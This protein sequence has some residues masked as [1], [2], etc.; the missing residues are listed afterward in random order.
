[1]SSV[2]ETDSTWWSTFGVP[3]FAAGVAIVPTCY[4]FARKTAEQLERPVPRWTVGEALKAGFKAIPETALLVGSQMV[5][6]PLVKSGIKQFRGTQE[7]PATFGETVASSCFVGT[8]TSPFFAA[9]NAKTASESSWEAVRKLTRRQ[10]GAVG[11]LEAAFVTGV[12]AGEHLHEEAKEYFGDT[13]LVQHGSHFVSGA[14]GGL[15][16]HPAN[17]LFTRWNSGLTTTP[18][19]LMLGGPARVV[20]TGAFTTI[21]KAV[22]DRFTS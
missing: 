15:L 22:Q 2:Q 10:V 20:A 9:F 7:S 21:Y 17:T 8:V 18:R 4:G 5:A 6:E 16:G 3:P 1:M 19:Q 11:V 13:P 12:S 14:F